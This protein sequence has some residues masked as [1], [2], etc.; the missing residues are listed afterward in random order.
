MKAYRKEYKDEFRNSA[1]IEKIL[2]HPAFYGD[3][4]KDPMYRLT[5]SADYD[6]GFMYH[7]S[8]YDSEKDAEDA[9]STFSCG[10]FRMIY[11]IST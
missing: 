5:L 2:N 3:T 11:E 8:V 7:V 9:L 10:T 6:G 1:T 4:T